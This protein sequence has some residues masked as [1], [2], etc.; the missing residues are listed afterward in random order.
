MEDDDAIS[1]ASTIMSEDRFVPPCRERMLTCLNN[2]WQIQRQSFSVQKLLIRYL[3]HAMG[4]PV[5]YVEIDERLNY[6]ERWFQRLM[7]TLPSPEEIYELNQQD[8]QLILRTC[9]R[10]FIEKIIFKYIFFQL[11]VLISCS[12]NNYWTSVR[13]A[14]I[15]YVIIWGFWIIPVL[16]YLG[17]FKFRFM[18]QESGI[19]YNMYVSLQRFSFVLYL[20]SVLGLL[21]K[22]TSIPFFVICFPMLLYVLGVAGFDTSV[23]IRDCKY[24]NILFILFIAI[25]NLFTGIFIGII[26]EHQV[27]VLYEQSNQT[28]P[29]SLSDNMSMVG[30]LFGLCQSHMYIPFVTYIFPGDLIN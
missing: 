27:D 2:F 26:M 29:G 1:E 19:L 3:S 10:P 30:G 16:L 21:V 23:P 7:G 11:A 20:P 9:A 28:M 4:V 25:C 14:T 5:E 8:L 18:S 12:W 13:N 15:V 17:S 24:E 22:L 6:H